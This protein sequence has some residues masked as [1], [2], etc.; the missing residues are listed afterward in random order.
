[1]SFPVEQL[2]IKDIDGYGHVW[3]GNY[4]K[5]FERGQQ[6]LL[7]SCAVRQ[8]EHLK[9]KRSVPWGAA[10]SRVESYLVERP[11]A[12]LARVYQRWRVGDEEHAVCLALVS[13]PPGCDAAVTAKDVRVDG[14][15][16]LWMA[17]KNLQ[18]GATK[19]VD[20]GTPPIGRL[21]YARH[22][23][24]DMV[25]GGEQSIQL[26]DV[27]DLFEQSRTEVVGGQPG[28][29]AFLDRGLALVVGQIDELVLAEDM[30]LTPGID[31]TC[32]V[33]LVREY[34]GR[35]CFDF[36]QRLLRADAHEV[37]RVRVQMCCVDPKSGELVPTPDDAWAEWLAR[38]TAG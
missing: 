15:P 8:I 21:R 18:T 10:R 6:R 35:R 33:T 31:V 20:P 5:F 2:G 36:Q 26:V 9:Y 25:S 16:K 32:E 24:A 3:Y 23:F 19:A 29:K 27:M 11:A 14:G 30:R 1:M 4:V 38:A 37:A 17:V 13:V 7:G 22:V 34:S 28:L 12:G